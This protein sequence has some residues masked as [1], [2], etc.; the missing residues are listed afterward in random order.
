[1]GMGMGQTSARKHKLQRVSLIQIKIAGGSGKP[2]GLR[3]SLTG[4][5]NLRR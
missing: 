1:M 5:T 4:K 2:I 3:S